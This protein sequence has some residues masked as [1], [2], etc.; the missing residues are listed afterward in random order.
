[1]TSQNVYSEKGQ[2][3]WGTAYML[4]LLITLQQS[5]QHS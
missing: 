2:L 3:M 4:A 5:L 1:M